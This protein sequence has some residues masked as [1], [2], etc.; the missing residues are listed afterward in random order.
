MSYLWNYIPYLSLNIRFR[1]FTTKLT[2][3][4]RWVK[5]RSHESYAKNYSIVFPHDEP[6]AC[7]DMTKGALHQVRVQTQT[8]FI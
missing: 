5:E 7:R 8:Y 4:Q 1:R 6:L 2:D 3:N